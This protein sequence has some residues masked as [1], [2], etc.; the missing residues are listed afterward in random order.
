MSGLTT[1]PRWNEKIFISKI[2]AATQDDLDRVGVFN[3]LES[4]EP[5]RDL[6]ESSKNKSIFASVS[7]G[8]S[9]DEFFSVYSTFACSS[10]KKLNLSKLSG[11][12]KKSR[13]KKIKKELIAKQ[14]Q[15]CVNFC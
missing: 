1:I 7:S 4:N 6:C 8:F 14:I 12:I 5:M 9:R 2:S 3:N 13:R 15:A 11:R 10:H